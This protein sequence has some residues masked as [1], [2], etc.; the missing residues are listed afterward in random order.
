MS[1][2]A[3]QL[4]NLAIIPV[5]VLEDAADAAPL[6]K[7]LSEGG[8][9]C[10]EVTFRTEAAAESIGRLTQEF[11]DLLVGAGTV[12]TTSQAQKAI[13]A[14]ARFIVSPGFNPRTADFCRQRGIDFFP[15]ICT[16]T[17]IEA[18]LDRGLTILKFFPSEPLGGLD[19]LKAIA[20]PFSTVRYIPTGGINPDNVR[21]YLSFD[22]VFAVGGTWLVKAEWIAAKRYD[23]VTERVW[24]AVQIVREMRGSR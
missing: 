21:K 24:E 17:E 22:K 6:G 4:E 14:G 10:A 7:A 20:A 16:P 5:I 19:Y 3:T 15:G 8:L 11:P 1:Q 18:A 23:L 12:L 2:I 9:P 13:D